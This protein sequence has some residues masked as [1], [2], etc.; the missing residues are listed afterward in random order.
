MRKSSEISKI[1]NTK[2]LLSNQDWEEEI[3]IQKHD[4]SL[5]KDG[6]LNIKQVSLISQ[7][8]TKR[9]QLINDGIRCSYEQAILLHFDI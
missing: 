8:A 1:R 4:L 7:K 3:S 2:I 5:L 6:N 9:L